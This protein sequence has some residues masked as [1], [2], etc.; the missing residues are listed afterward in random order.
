MLIFESDMADFSNRICVMLD[1]K[2]DFKQ[3]CTKCIH[4]STPYL[5]SKEKDTTCKEKAMPLNILL[6]HDKQ[7]TIVL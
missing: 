2:Y 5:F 3:L 6:I 7:N 4:F 1:F